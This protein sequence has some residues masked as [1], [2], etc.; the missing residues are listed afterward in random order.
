MKNAT[1]NLQLSLRKLTVR[2]VKSKIFFQNFLLLSMIFIVI[3]SLFA[4]AFFSLARETIQKEYTYSV[5][6]KLE[7]TAKV[8]DGHL[9]DMRYLIASLNQNSMVNAFFTYQQPERI[10]DF[11]HESI[12]QMLSVYTHSLPSV[13]SIYLYSGISETI[14]TSDEH[15]AQES[16]DDMYWKD[17]VSTEH[18]DIQFFF[19]SIQGHYPYVLSIIKQSE[20]NGHHSAIVVNLK[21]N[22]LTQLK[23]LSR[24]SYQKVYWVSDHGELVYRY[25]QAELT[26]PL[27]II[28]ELVNF[29]ENEYTY[30]NL[31]EDSTTPY[32]YSQIHSD[33]Y[34]WS[35]VMV[36]YLQEYTSLLNNFLV[37]FILILFALISTVLLFVFFLCF[38][39]FK[40]IYNLL[41]L[42]QKSETALQEDIY[43]HDEMTY[44]AD[45]ITSYIQANQ[46]LTTELS[47][48]LEIL[49]QTKLLALQAQINPHF[50][51]NTLSVINMQQ[52][53]ELGYTHKLPKLTLELSRLLRY[54]IE[55]T[56]LVVLETE[57][58]YAKIYI[59]ILQERY[60]NKPKVH[61]NIEPASLSA[62]IPKLII[63]PIVEN[64]VFHGLAGNMNENSALTLSCTTDN[65]FCILSVRDNG[66][67]MDKEV[68][69]NLLHSLDESVPLNN[70]IG[71]KNVV[72]RM[73]LLY[74]ND[75]TIKIESIKGEGTTFTLRFPLSN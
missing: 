35:Y 51:F 75:F 67:G 6:Y 48:R 73:H 33:R 68:L 30:T 29:N 9:H 4:I 70:N 55:S 12:Q 28:P 59:H 11:Y 36:T 24:E 23:K 62:K 61:Y 31:I 39:T 15:I 46:T 3:F 16:F 21:L 65:S 34:L 54:A 66:V 1:N 74:S 10:Y 63:Q 19:R 58:E 32:I 17:L 64:A 71:V 42:F 13:Y 44:I 41:Q 8:V 27:S 14:L 69:E 72:T 22:E 18:E 49:N 53:K 26:E 25:D 20:I 5:K 40:P 38:R 47:A 45:Q 52:C 57:L 2:L 50:L 7:E 43:S 60:N 56:D 37:A